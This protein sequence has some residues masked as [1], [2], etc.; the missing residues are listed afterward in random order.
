MDRETLV[1]LMAV[2]PFEPFEVRMSNGEVHRVKHPEVALLTKNKLLVYDPE[3]DN[4]DILSLLHV[5]RAS[6]L[7]KT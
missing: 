7:Q 3:T 5:N 4:L 6:Q 2:R 1:K